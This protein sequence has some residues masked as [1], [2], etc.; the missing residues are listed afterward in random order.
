MKIL[1]GDWSIPR[2]PICFLKK[3]LLKTKS[4][5]WW[6]K[7][8]T[9]RDVQNPV[10]NE[11]NYLSIGTGFLPSTL[12]VSVISYDTS[13]GPCVYLPPVGP[14]LGQRC[15]KWSEGC[16]PLTNYVLPGLL[17]GF[18]WGRKIGIM[19]VPH[20]TKKVKASEL[21]TLTVF[22][23]RVFRVYQASLHQSHPIW[24]ML[25]LHIW[26]LPTSQRTKLA[27]DLI[28]L[29]CS[30]DILVIC[31][32]SRGQTFVF[33]FLIPWEFCWFRFGC[34]Y[35]CLF[36]LTLGRRDVHIIKIYRMHFVS[37]TPS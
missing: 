8:C 22:P 32:M 19:I 29:I 4:H 7:S 23:Q 14:I 17:R 33:L 34:G 5:C 30:F 1:S 16:L 2:T 3:P 21:L 27:L 10:N 18:F 9:A 11:I 36:Q 15:P 6:K 37:T 26:G 28:A 35:G 31:P 20:P 24:W 13:A 25:P 12:S